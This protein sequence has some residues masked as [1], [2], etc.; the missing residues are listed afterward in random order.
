MAKNDVATLGKAAMGV[1]RRL[2]GENKLLIKAL[3]PFAGIYA[4]NEQLK[5]DLDAGISRYVA[6]LYPKM[7][8]SKAAF[9]LVWKY[10]KQGE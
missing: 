7:A 5:P 10:R 2:E 1:I 4:M 8:E 3:I 9:D 6:G